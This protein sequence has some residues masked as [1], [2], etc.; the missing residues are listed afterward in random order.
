MPTTLTLLRFLI[1]EV[2]AAII[3]HPGPWQR[4]VLQPQGFH[5]EMDQRAA[6]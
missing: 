3:L 6:F 4:D 5:Q 1:E 2:I